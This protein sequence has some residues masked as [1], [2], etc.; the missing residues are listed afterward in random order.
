MKLRSVQLLL[1]ADYHHS[2]QALTHIINDANWYVQ[3]EC[4]QSWKNVIGNGS[5][6]QAPILMKTWEPVIGFDEFWLLVAQRNSI[7]N[8][9][10]Y[11][12]VCVPYTLI[13]TEQPKR[14]TIIHIQSFHKSHHIKIKNKKNF[15]MCIMNQPVTGLVRF[16]KQ[17]YVR[18]ASVLY[19]I[20]SS[21]NNLSIHSLCFL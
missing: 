11:M 21:Q 9:L 5:V 8:A 18:F 15:N 2:Y 16:S 12:A 10:R 13:S 19:Q 14:Q 6:C 7:H 20:F 1:A 4:I 3:S 17:D